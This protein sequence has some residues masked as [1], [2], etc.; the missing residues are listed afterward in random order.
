[1]LIDFRIISIFTRKLILRTST[2]AL[3]SSR[4]ASHYWVCL[5]VE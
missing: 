2:V 3:E 4:K 5:W 1:M